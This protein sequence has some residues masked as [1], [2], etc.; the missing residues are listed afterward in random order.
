MTTGIRV[1][2]VPVKKYTGMLIIYLN[3]L[4]LI[5]DMI[6]AVN[7]TKPDSFEA[8]DKY[9]MKLAIQFMFKFVQILG[10]KNS[11]KMGLHFLPSLMKFALGGIP[12]FTLLV[13]YAGD[14]QHEVD[15]K[16]QALQQELSKFNVQIEIA[17]NK[18]EASD[19]WV[20]RRESFN[21]LRKNV[22]DKHTAP[23]IDDFIVPPDCLVDFFPKLKAILEKYQLLY[24]IAGHMGNG[25]FHI[26]PLM[27]L[28][29]ASERAKILDCANDVYDLV[30][31]YHG[32]FS[33][34]HN[35]GLIRGPFLAK[36]YS[37][38]MVKIF[39]EIKHIFDPED[40]FNPHKKIDANFEFLK[41]HIRTG[42]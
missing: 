39:K 24:T 16:V 38:E 32:S 42:F 41:S 8:F 33:A 30:K 25:N 1:K 36:Q 20:I 12:E 40:I 29:I 21:L 9:T 18:Q 26:I 31:E 27:D 37:P 15:T 3:Q 23:F 11:V 22:K 7:P 2:L 5:P 14:T 10:I 19:Y 34:E 4:D 28:G 35:D 17:K 6:Q 13:E